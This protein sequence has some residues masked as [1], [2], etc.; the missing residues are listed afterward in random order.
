MDAE[1]LV[2]IASTGPFGPTAM[3]LMLLPVF[4]VAPF[5][6]LAI[7]ARALLGAD[8]LPRW[9]FALLVVGVVGCG[10]LVWPARIT[11]RWTGFWGTWRIASVALLALFPIVLFLEAGK[12]DW[13]RYL[14][15]TPKRKSKRKRDGTDKSRGGDGVFHPHGE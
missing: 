12:R 8:P 3:M 4:L 9:M 11:D 13:F 15:R 5:L 2:L 14:Q 1:S 6:L 7:T 10:F